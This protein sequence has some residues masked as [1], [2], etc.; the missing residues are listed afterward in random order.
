[1][2]I[3]ADDPF[4]AAWHA[5]QAGLNEEAGAKSR[6]AMKRAWALSAYESASRH[7]GWALESSA[8]DGVDPDLLFG[9]LQF[10]AENYQET[11]RL[12]SA[13]W[14]RQEPGS[15]HHADLQWLIGY[16]AIFGLE[17]FDRGRELLETVLDRFEQEGMVRECGYLR[18]SIAYA[19]F[20][21]RQLDSALQAENEV[22]ESARAREHPDN[23]LLSL[24]QLNRGRLHRTLGD[25][26]E[27]LSEFENGIHGQNAGLSPYMLSLFHSS[28]GHLRMSRGDYGDAL[29]HYHH[30]LNLVRALEIEAAIDRTL[31][32]ISR[33]ASKLSL[34]HLMRGDL[35]L[36]FVHFNLAI[37]SRALG[38]ERYEAAYRN[39]LDRQR[40]L[41]GEA[42][43][44]SLT[45]T[46]DEVEA[47]EPPHLSDELESF[48]DEAASAIAA[49]ERL[50]EV[51]ASGDGAVDAVID[52][53]AAGS[54][55]A[56][57]LPHRVADDVA[58]I[59]SFVLHDPRQPIRSALKEELF[60]TR[61]S[62]LPAPRSALTLPGRV[63]LFTGLDPLPL[64]VQESSLRPDLWARFP[65]IFPIQT[66]V[67]VLDPE[68]DGLLHQIVD[69]FAERTGC[70]FVT[71]SPFHLLGRPDLAS[72]PAEAVHDFLISSSDALLLG[73]RLLMKRLGAMRRQNLLPFRPNLNGLSWRVVT[74]EASLARD[75]S[76]GR[77]ALFLH[78]HAPGASRQ[79]IKVRSEL[80]P[81][82]EMCNGKSSV[83]E[84]VERA[85]HLQLI[86]RPE[87][88]D[89]L[90]GFLRQ[91]WLQ[92]ILCFDDPPVAEAVHA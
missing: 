23:F 2:E 13:C 55:V 57:L 87:A 62:A 81:L 46:L 71:A 5:R 58:R 75:A 89:A 59:D 67:Q 38:L 21:T 16:N 10:E 15:V 32:S 31:Y 29:S 65:G 43:W 37:A 76:G 12:L 45:S 88:S 82:L 4:A 14:E 8:L 33:H 19:L 36:L 27:A 11:D 51:S 66:R 77:D 28:S 52:A 44:E 54:A 20:R 78:S 41:I 6:D 61:L 26:D 25:S 86:A 60:N 85:H 7:A 9:L 91:L 56:V 47:S 40:D 79:L 73:D 34:G 49:V 68:F 24:L 63:E 74:R 39:A 72:D 90:C 42:V 1:M 50:V 17:Q 70:G 80:V 3:E 84:I 48:D 53:L 64:I 22:I 83:E 92:G 30:T 18:N 69:G 35:M